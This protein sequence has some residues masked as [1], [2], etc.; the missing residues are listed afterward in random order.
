MPFS[1]TLPTM[2]DNQNANTNWF[3]TNESFFLHCR[4]KMCSLHTRVQGT[5]NTHKAMPNHTLY[6]QQCQTTP[7]THSH[8]KPYLIHTA[9]PDHTPRTQPCPDHTSR[10]SASG[11]SSLL[12]VTV[13]YPS[14]FVRRGFHA[15][16]ILVMIAY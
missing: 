6:T 2:A 1:R 7:Y 8:A 14:S 16:C 3:V 12:S 9:M 10:S 11:P 5:F 15:Y 4:R 13:E